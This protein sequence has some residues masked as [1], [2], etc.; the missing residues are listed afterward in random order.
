MHCPWKNHALGLAALF[1]LRTNNAMKL[2]PSLHFILF[3]NPSAM[4]EVGQQVQEPESMIGY[5]KKDK[6]IMSFCEFAS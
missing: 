5:E 3:S 2:T 4:G 1:Y 6:I